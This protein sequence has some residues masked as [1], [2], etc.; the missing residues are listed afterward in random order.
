M[1][2]PKSSSQSLPSF[3]G[4]LTGKTSKQANNTDTF[5]RFGLNHP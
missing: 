5:L 3:L 4:R 1:D 2:V